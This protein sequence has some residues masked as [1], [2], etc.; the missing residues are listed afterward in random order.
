[1]GKSGGANPGQSGETRE[2][3][4]CGNKGEVLRQSEEARVGQ[5]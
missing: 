3:G 2:C 5:S 4:K 1:M